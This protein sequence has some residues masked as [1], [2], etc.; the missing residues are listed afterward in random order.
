MVH[1]Q[2]RFQLLVREG[3]SSING[4]RKAAEKGVSW[5]PWKWFPKKWDE[6]DCDVESKPSQVSICGEELLCWVRRAH[7]WGWRAEE[8]RGSGNHMTAGVYT[9]L[10]RDGLWRLPLGECFIFF[11]DVFIIYLCVWVYRLHA[12]MC[13]ASTEARE[14]TRSPGA[15]VIDSCKV[16]CGCWKLNWSL[17]QEQQVFVT[18]GTFLQ[19]Q[20]WFSFLKLCPTVQPRLT[21]RSSSSCPSLPSA[22][23]TGMPHHAWLQMLV[24]TYLFHC[25]SYDDTQTFRMIVLFS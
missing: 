21:F 1:C 22:G 24:K 10:Q 20:S 11:K 13:L 19:S 18:A 12:S 17:L 15:R 7:R 8:H 9:W 14:D 3:V 2:Q 23:K 5:W 25:L 16:P 4:Q 6:I